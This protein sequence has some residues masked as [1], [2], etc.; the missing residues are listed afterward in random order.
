M[1][2]LLRGDI[3][4]DL[5]N[6]A[7]DYAINIIVTDAGLKLPDSALFD[8]KYR[9]L[10]AKQIAK[11]LGDDQQQQQ[12]QPQDAQGDDEKPSGAPSNP[13]HAGGDMGRY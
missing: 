7:C 3:N 10:S 9:G 11:L 1:H 5:W 12:S 2:H 6:Q 8:T 4:P 13:D